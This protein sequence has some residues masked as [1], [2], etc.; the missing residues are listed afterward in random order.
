M[1]H[2]RNEAGRLRDDAV[3]LSEDLRKLGDDAREIASDRIGNATGAVRDF[4]ESK[5]LQALLIAAGAGALLSLF[6]RGRR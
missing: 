4:V 6:F 1:K 5:P 3:R 2:M